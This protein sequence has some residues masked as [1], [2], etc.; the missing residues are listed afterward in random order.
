M[1][2]I[3]YTKKTPKGEVYI[4][5]L[6]DPITAEIRYIGKTLVSL[7]RRLTRHIY[8]ALHGGSDFAVSRWIRKLATSEQ[9]PVIQ[10]FETATDETWQDSEQYWIAY[11]R[12]H[13]WNLLNLTDGGEGMPGAKLSEETK[14]IL[15]LQKQGEKS[16]TAK[17]TDEIVLAIREAYHNGARQT[18]LAQQY[19]VT[20]GTIGDIVRGRRWKHLGGHIAEPQTD[21]KG[22]NGG[23]SKL[24][25]VEVI[26]IRQAYADGNVT[27]KVLAQKYG[28]S[29]ET[30]AGVVKR[31]NWKHIE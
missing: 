3:K 2:E 7:N 12:T 17:L 25:N 16:V 24:T 5:T 23:K 27:Q 29:K 22:E 11:G 20:A 10:W 6:I 8:D 31:R 21:F 4:Y 30:I 14:H 13:E 28:V 9:K 15:R 19:G 1:T 18:H 26:A